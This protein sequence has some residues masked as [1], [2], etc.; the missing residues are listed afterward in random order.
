MPFLQV[1]PEAL[2]LAATELDALAA[3]LDTAA[4]TANAA[5]RPLPPGS[6]EV[7]LLTARYFHTTA[8]SFT[9]AVARGTAELRATAATLRQQAAQYVAQDVATGANLSAQM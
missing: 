6:E 9:P 5:I 2:L 8:G 1:R 7:S 4:A 3:R